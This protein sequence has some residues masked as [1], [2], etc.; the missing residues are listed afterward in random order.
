M[1]NRGVLVEV[2]AEHHGVAWIVD[3]VPALVAQHNPDAVVLDS[4]SQARSLV[5]PLTNAGVTTTTT[6]LKAMVEACGAFYDA[7]QEGRLVHRD[8]PTLNA[9]IEGAKQRNVGDAWA[10]ARRTSA[11]NVTPL[12]AATLALW[13]TTQARRRPL[14]DYVML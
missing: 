1:R 10:W 3:E 4:A 5:A 12:V 13:G 2:L 14:S 7:I 11:S 8:D 6:D 9:A